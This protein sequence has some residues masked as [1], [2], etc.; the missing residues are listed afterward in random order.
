[1]PEGDTLDRTA[2]VLVGREV[3]GARA[4][5]M[6]RRWGSSSAVGSIA[7]SRSAG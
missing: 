1:M 5:P 6:G 4:A 2:Q 7:W 3:L